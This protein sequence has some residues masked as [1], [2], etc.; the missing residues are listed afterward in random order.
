MPKKLN[1]KA[2]LWTSLSALVL[3]IVALAIVIV[4]LLNKNNGETQTV[5]KQDNETQVSTPE[6]TE[7]K[8]DSDDWV[9]F[10]LNEKMVF[11]TQEM[12]VN[13]SEL[14]T[15]IQESGAYSSP[16]YAGDGAKFLIVNMTIKNT[17]NQPLTFRALSLINQDGDQYEEYSGIGLVDNYLTV[18]DLPPNIPETG[19]VVFRVSSDSTSFKI[20]GQNSGTGEVYAVDLK[21]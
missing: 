19:N 6:S 7:V 5:N 18:R 9:M 12:Q 13:S 20:F 8:S 21:P 16:E 15:Y 1:R 4:F 17:T 10:D 3:I 2:I 11:A 14:A